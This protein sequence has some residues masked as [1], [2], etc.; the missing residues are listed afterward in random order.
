[1]QVSTRK[2]LGAAIGLMMGMLPVAQADA[3]LAWEDPGAIVDAFVELALHSDYSQRKSPL[4]KWTDPVRYQLVHRVGDKDLHAG[5]VELHLDHLSAL[6]GLRI[7][8][9][10]DSES[11][12]LVIVMTSDQRMEF[13]TL[14]FTGGDASGRRERVFRD[15]MCLAS[16][17]T[18]RQGAIQ[19]A[20]VLIPVDRARGRG[21]L[22]GCVI[23]ELTHV[24]GLAN[25]TE[26]PLPS[27]F[28]HGTTRSFLTGLD[29][30]LLKV[31]YDPRLRPG[32]VE[33]AVRPVA[34]QI[35]VELE[36]SGTIAAA[37]RRAAEAGLASLSP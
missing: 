6:T 22:V 30:I 35:A 21:E 23:E 11:A 16:L 26:R 31:L 13:D 17:R 2:W 19:R 4:R 5:L 27:I 37:E 28:H 34:R 15:T 10:A 24:M 33:S 18:D 36:R 9:A 32:M 8:R 7:E 20:A 3:G 12:N 29:T 1:M 14:A 25:D